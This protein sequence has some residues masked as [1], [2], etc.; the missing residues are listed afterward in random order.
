M[1]KK[2][3]SSVSPTKR[4]PKPKGERTL[5]AA[6]YKRLSRSRMLTKGSVEVMF[7]LDA[8]TANFLDQFAVSQNMTRSQVA[9]VFLDFAIARIGGAV[10]QAERLLD[11]GGSEV[12]LADLI[13][14]SLNTTPPPDAVAKYKE[15][16]GIK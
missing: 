10:A 2:A 7:R 15:V 9:E 5:T 14:D 11:Q 3:P 6:E 1:S 8:G 4:G 12:A 13:R 16:L